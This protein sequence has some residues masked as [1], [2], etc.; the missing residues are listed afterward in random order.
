DTG[1]S[2]AAGRQPQPQVPVLAALEALVEPAD[3]LDERAADEPGARGDEVPLDQVRE[4]VALA[5]RPAG[6][7]QG[8]PALVDVPPP[9]VGDPDLGSRIEH[10]DLPGEGRREE[11]VVVVQENDVRALRGAQPDVARGAGSPVLLPEVPDPLAKAGRHGGRAVGRSVVD[12]RDLDRRMRLPERALD[13]LA[14]E[15]SAVVR[16]DDHA[17]ERWL[18][19]LH[20]RDP[21]VVFGPPGEVKPGVTPRSRGPAAGPRPGRGPRR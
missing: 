14:D 19:A 18:R 6:E 8:P 5:P 3:G 10:V 9:A 12:D 13:R 20:P 15:A 1:P 11:P 2:Q 7:R 4:D 21:G 16:G 17:H